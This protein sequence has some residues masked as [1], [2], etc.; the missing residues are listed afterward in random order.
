[1]NPRPKRLST[2]YFNDISDEDLDTLME[3]LDIVKYVEKNNGYSRRD[4]CYILRNRLEIYGLPYFNKENFLNDLKYY[5][6]N[7]KPKLTI[8]YIS[9]KSWEERRRRR[10]N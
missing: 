3:L 9:G 6:E 10:D 1:M 8:E 7:V 2:G 4:I 5:I